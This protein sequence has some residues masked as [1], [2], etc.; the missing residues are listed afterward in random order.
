MAR[1]PAVA[2]RELT[3]QDLVDALD[4]LADLRIAV[5][6]DY[7]Y[8]Y[9]GD[10]A[11]ERGYLAAYAESP[12]AVVVGAFADGA[13]V[14]AA[15]AAPMAD[16]ATEFAAPFRDRGM[17]IGAIYYFGESVLLPE[18]RG[19]GM[20]HAFFDRREAKARALGFAVTCFCAV[21]R[22]QDHPARPADYAPLDPFW[23]KRGYAPVEGLIG[24]FGWKDRGEAQESQ[25]LMQFWVKML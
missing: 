2:I 16:H 23:R 13:L 12:G 6:A 3:G 5:F 7:P 1:S 4:R 20:G 24:Q 19:H 8:L 10:R 14:G 9:D 22:P 25:H 18:W 11:Y 15:T 17:D 21:V